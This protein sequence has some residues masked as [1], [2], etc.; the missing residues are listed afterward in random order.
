MYST[1]ILNTERR[2][3]INC[4]KIYFYDVERVSWRPLK[5]SGFI[6]I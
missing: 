1:M 3:Q 5:I 6:G 2:V 4:F